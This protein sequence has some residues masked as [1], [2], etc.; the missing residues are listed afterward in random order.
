MKRNKCTLRASTANNIVMLL[1]DVMYTHIMANIGYADLP[2]INFVYRVRQIISSIGL[3]QNVRKPYSPTR[4]LLAA[5]QIFMHRGTSETSTGFTLFTNV[6]ANRRVSGG[7][8]R[9]GKRNVL[10]RYSVPGGH[11]S[12]EFH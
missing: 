9:G 3:E 12:A 10:Q 6:F 7:K 4:A 5:L 11:V 8:G 2:M 1:R